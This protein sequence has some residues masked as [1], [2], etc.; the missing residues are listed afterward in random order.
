MKVFKKT[1]F[2]I[3][4]SASMLFATA[5]GKTTNPPTQTATEQSY[6]FEQGRVVFERN[7]A[8]SLVGS[9]ITVCLLIWLCFSA[10]LSLQVQ[11]YLSHFQQG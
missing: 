9:T 11:F 2:A 6:S 3:L 1:L 4:L 8:F 5:C 7:K 10:W